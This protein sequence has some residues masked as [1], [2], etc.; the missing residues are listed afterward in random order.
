MIRVEN[1]N[2][3]VIDRV[4]KDEFE[5]PAAQKLATYDE[6]GLADEWNTK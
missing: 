5:L 4:M 2:K 3:A 1:K 6:Q